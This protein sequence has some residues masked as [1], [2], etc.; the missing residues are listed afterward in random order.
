[1]YFRISM[2]AAEVRQSVPKLNLINDEF[3]I[4]FRSLLGYSLTFFFPFDFNFIYGLG[5]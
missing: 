5:D 2:Q 4:S 1:M 3:L